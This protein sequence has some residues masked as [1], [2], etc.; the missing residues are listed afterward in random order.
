LVVANIGGSDAQILES[1]YRFLVTD[2]GLP[3]S[4]P[5]KSDYVKLLLV[6]DEPLIAHES[7]VVS[8]ELGEPLGRE[9]GLIGSRVIGYY[10]M[11]VMGFI[12]YSDVIT[13][14]ERYMGFCRVFTP[15]VGIN[16]LQG[17]FV[18]VDNQD[19]EYED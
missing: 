9:A 3:M 17:R 1:G 8:V 6:P 4:P 10:E 7:R 13:G 11:F 16:K 19:Y 15:P 12:R 5:F 2:K 14:R 18:P